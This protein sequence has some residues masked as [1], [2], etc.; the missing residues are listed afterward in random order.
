MSSS[1]PPEDMR[2]PWIEEIRYRTATAASNT[3]PESF[4]EAVGDISV[5]VGALDRLMNALAEIRDEPDREAVYSVPAKAMVCVQAYGR[6]VIEV[7]D[8][9]VAQARQFFGDEEDQRMRLAVVPGY[10]IAGWEHKP[11]GKGYKSF[12]ANVTVRER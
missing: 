3:R 5:L 12:V 6:N 2:I 8:Y 9:A 7:E 10:E 1:R 4:S 11:T